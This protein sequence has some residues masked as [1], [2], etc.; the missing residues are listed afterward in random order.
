MAHQE[1]PVSIPNELPAD[2]DGWDRLIDDAFG[3]GHFQRW[4]REGDW[5]VLTGM[6]VRLPATMDGR[7]EGT[8]KL[9]VLADTISAAGRTKMASVEFN[10]MSD[11]LL[12]GRTVDL[13]NQSAWRRMQGE[14]TFRIAVLNSPPSGWLHLSVDGVGRSGGTP[15]PAQFRWHAGTPVP[16]RIEFYRGET[17][18][19]WYGT[20]ELPLP[21][22]GHG[23]DDSCRTFLAR[24]L[25]TA[26]GLLDAG[27][28]ADAD[29][30][31]TRL[32]SLLALH[33]GAVSWHAIAGQCMALRGML[34]PPLPGSDR[35][36]DLNPTVYG[37]VAT[38]YAKPL[39]TFAG[40]F[41]RF[42]DRS[43]DFA[44]RQQAAQLMLERE[45]KAIEFRALV[46]RQLEAN[47]KAADDHLARA[48]ASIEAQGQRIEQ[49]E[50]AFNEGL[51]EW[52][53]AQRRAADLAIAGA[54]FSAVVGIGKALAGKP[55]DPASLAAQ[56]VKAGAIAVKVVETLKHINNIIKITAEL[57][58]MSQEINRQIE[59]MDDVGAIANGVT[60]MR[61]EADASDLRGAPSESAYWDQFQVEIRLA[62][63]P[64]LDEGIPGA[65]DYLQQ[66]EVLVIYG[67]A[68]TAAQAAIPPITQELAQAKML[69]RIADEQKDALQHQ[70]HALRDGSPPVE[71]ATTLWLNHRSVRRAMFAALQDF[72]AAHRYWALTARS[73][74]GDPNLPI[75]RF[76]NDL[77]KIADIPARVRDAL[78][79]FHPRPQ[80]FRIRG[81]EVPAE[82]VADFLRDGS[83][84][85]R[86]TPDTVTPDGR[87]VEGRGPFAGRGL[88][89]RVR[90]REVAVWLVWKGDERPESVEFTVRTEGDYQDQ[91]VHAGKPQTFRF[92]GP[93]VN[94]TFEYDPR[95]ERTLR[96]AAAAL[97][98]AIIVPA[99]V[100]EEFRFEYSE[101]TLFTGWNVHLPRDRA[102]AIDPE[103]LAALRGSVAGILMDFSGS[104]IKEDNRF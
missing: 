61:R 89:G 66:L 39:R 47:L 36:P 82:A 80:D 101:P 46:T 99:R 14:E 19:E 33:P 7:P 71:L 42:I 74:P 22:S 23:L 68:L 13:G 45:S 37:T 32:E 60:H 73:E 86:F 100:A 30:V 70:V 84:T 81:F 35:V 18:F 63:M 57:V 1:T 43:L 96:K 21:A 103:W 95:K 40:Q 41:E 94:K 87:L 53:R 29:R 54:V 55:M 6:H 24:L 92:T 3:M 75:A 12:L 65:R 93:R 62:L 83:F 72:D 90:V 48:Q 88:A 49:A 78:A 44:H 69:A 31:L 59:R 5:W 104:Y 2:A 11:V 25:L 34:R 16:H 50:R 56:A 4:N 58:K 38:A 17:D 98:N 102:G 8:S 26:Q 76:V 79:S 20:R 97:D 51:D 9:L 91:L 52:R 27:R 85:L 64:T 67:R 10:G 15:R 28:P 77:I